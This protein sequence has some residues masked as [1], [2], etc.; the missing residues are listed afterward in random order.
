[1]SFSHQQEVHQIYI[2]AKQL[3]EKI[4]KQNNVSNNI[5]YFIFIYILFMCHL[6]LMLCYYVYSDVK[7]ICLY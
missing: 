2:N 6:F 5:L 7:T 3:C 1:M 4:T